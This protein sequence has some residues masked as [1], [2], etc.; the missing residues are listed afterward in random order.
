MAD[1]VAHLER[2]GLFWVST[3]RPDGRPHVTPVF[4]VWMDESS[5]MNSSALTATPG[6]PGL[7]GPYS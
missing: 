4:A 1:A 6:S 5:H 7:T 2:A 3:V